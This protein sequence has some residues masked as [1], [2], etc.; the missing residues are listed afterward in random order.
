MGVLEVE[1]VAVTVLDVDLVRLFFE[2][3][4]DGSYVGEL[5]LLGTMDSE[6]EELFDGECFDLVFVNVYC[7]EGVGLADAAFENVV[8]ALSMGGVTDQ[9]SESEPL[10]VLVLVPVLKADAVKLPFV[11]WPVSVSDRVSLT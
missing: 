2:M 8:V 6:G 1:K 4:A 3:E 11:L 5:L 9:V 7:E 10:L